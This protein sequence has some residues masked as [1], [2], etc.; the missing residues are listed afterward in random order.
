MNVLM[1]LKPKKD[2]AYIY[3]TSTLRQALEKMR[4]HGYAAI[5][6]LSEDGRYVGSISEGDFLWYLVDEQC[7]SSKDQERHYVKDIIRS[8]FS[9]AVRINVTMDELLEKAMQQN[10]ICVTDDSDSFIGIVTRRDIIRSMLKG[11]VKPQGGRAGGQA[12]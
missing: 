12:L 2:V 4:H 8:D 11:T 5:P 9:P 6:V 7:A 10:F 1:L 3:E